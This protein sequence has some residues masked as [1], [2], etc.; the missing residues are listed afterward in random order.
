M[1]LKKAKVNSCGWVSAY[2]LATRKVPSNFA[3]TCIKMPCKINSFTINPN[4]K[5]LTGA[6]ISIGILNATSA[7][8]GL[9]CLSHC[10]NCSR[11]NH[12]INLC[13]NTVTKSQ[14]HSSMISKI[15]KKRKQGFFHGFTERETPNSYIIPEYS[16]DKAWASLSSAVIK[17]PILSHME[18]I[19]L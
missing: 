11:F 3:N 2:T 15:A 6:T 18:W 19:R 7:M 14:S 8:I 1:S 13:P 9:V 4:A 5:R 10:S 17:H 16:C 12:W